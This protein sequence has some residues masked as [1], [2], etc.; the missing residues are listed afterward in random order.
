MPTSEYSNILFASNFFLFHH[1][2]EANSII[3]QFQYH[4]D[5]LGAELNYGWLK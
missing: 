5:T 1:F 3:N 4:F 2:T